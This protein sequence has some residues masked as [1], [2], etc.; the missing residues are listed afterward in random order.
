MGL[1]SLFFSSTATEPA[2]G[3]FMS[4]ICICSV[5]MNPIVK[6]PIQD[7]TAMLTA[8][9]TAMRMIEATTGL[10]ALL[11]RM[12]FFMYFSLLFC[13]WIMVD[14]K[15]ILNLITCDT[16]LR[17]NEIPKTNSSLTSLSYEGA[18]VFSEHQSSKIQDTLMLF[19]EGEYKSLRAQ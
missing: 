7:A 9:V 2:L 17:K 1:V 6:A 16:I 8:T 15:I 5:S 3:K 10:R 11:L 13:Y 18:M 12:K 14:I 4:V 19:I